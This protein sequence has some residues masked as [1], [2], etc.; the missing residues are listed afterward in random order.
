MNCEENQPGQTP[1]AAHHDKPYVLR[2][3]ARPDLLRHECLADLLTASARRRPQHPALIWGER[4][5]SYGE[6]DAS[7]A[8]LAGALRQRG[9][10]A[11]RII[12]LFLPRG[13]DLL[14]AQAGITKSGAAWLPFD[15]ETPWERIRT[16]LQS[17]N[18]IG[19][20]TCREWLP[21]L[22][23]I[24][25]PVWPVEDL[26][27]D[28]KPCPA[29]AAA[30]PSDPA[31]VI[32]TS[33]STGQ[34]KGIVISQRSICHFLRS[35]N[36]ILGVRE[37]DLV[38]QGFSVAFDMS[39]EEIWISHL[40][41]A[42][43]WIAPPSLVG[44]PDL[45]AQT[46]TRERITVLH[47]IP[48]LLSLVDDPLPTMRLINLGGE[49][50]P[51]GL[52]QR[53]VRPG[54]K[55]F[56][57]YGP[58]ETAVSATAAEL[59][60]DQRVT[61]GLPL[62]NY[63]LLVV[64]EQRR[65]LPAGKAGELC[66]FG[67]GLA[68]GYLGQPDLTAQRFVA[69]PL[70]AG[71]D[72]QLMYLTGDLARIEPGGPVHCLGRADNQVKIRGFRIELDEVTAALAAQPGVGMAAV[73][74]RPLAEIDQLI[75]FVVPATNQ[76]VEPDS[77]RQALAARL[78]H[79]MVPAHFELVTELPRLASGKIDQNAL[80]VYPFK[81]A[82][83]KDQTTEPRNEEEAAL[84]G[85][86]GKLFL[87]RAWRPESD[88][89]DDLGGHSLLAARLVSILRT[90]ERYASLSIQDVYQKRQL[91][92]IAAAMEQQRRRKKTAST[93]HTTAPWRRR[94]LCGLAQAAVI[95]FLVLFHI[96]SWLAPFFV[97]HYYTGDPGDRVS[98]AVL[99]SLITFVFVETITFAVAI[100]GK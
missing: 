99:Y 51:D 33:G 17:A 81:S 73:V 42:T 83:P 61:I 98:L 55:V 14:I 64:D 48:T 52:A 7:S 70:A 76:K 29:C 9:A 54:R 41:G 96:A 11:G 28:E 27:A 24:K 94:F 59:K 46:L 18:A 92:G 57:T 12:G 1:A 65:P 20:V 84:Y 56:N 78:P 91:S 38:Y 30:Q 74:V 4:I 16:C 72:E 3:P 95:P 40:V 53:L 63:G 35:E 13:A 2:G 8:A 82:K 26:L 25:L 62:P 77:L 37:N 32:Y 6:L 75:S 100:A 68:T 88:F 45:L 23:E 10:G 71:S 90:D 19:L 58:T 67:P 44:D 86:L 34:P 93:P 87:E 5:V 31:Y 50:C 49:A 47:A 97:Y 80:R 66:I 85:A 36:E 39:F 15:A 43:L 79:Y 89:F 21:R 69:N 22:A 60:P